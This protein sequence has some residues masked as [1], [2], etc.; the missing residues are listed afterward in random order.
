M[1]RPVALHLVRRLAQ[2]DPIHVPRP[3]VSHDDPEVPHLPEGV[4]APVEVALD[5]IDPGVDDGLPETHAHDPTTLEDVEASA[6]HLDKDTVLRVPGGVAE[7]VG[8]LHEKHLLRVPQHAPGRAL[9]VHLARRGVRHVRVHVHHPRAPAERELGQLDHE[10]VV[11][12]DREPVLARVDAL[13]GARHLP[14]HVVGLVTR[15]AEFGHERPRGRLLV[16]TAT[17]DLELGRRAR[18]G[19]REAHARHDEVV[20]SCLVHRSRPSPEPCLEETRGHHA[21]RGGRA[22]DVLATQGDLER[23]VVVARLL[24]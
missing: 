10:R 21:D 2:V 1:A 14:I 8:R 22:H 6:P 16:G 7:P 17:G 24:C 19:T 15:G 11:P 3:L 13:P 5:A 12:R 23:E 20:S 9:S 18:H 4:A